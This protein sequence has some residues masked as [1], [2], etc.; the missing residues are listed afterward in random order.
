[1]KRQVHERSDTFD[2]R[3]ITTAFSGLFLMNGNNVLVRQVGIVV[4]LDIQVEHTV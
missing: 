3:N 1:M 4:N 2:I